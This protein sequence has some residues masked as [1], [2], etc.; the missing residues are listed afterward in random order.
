VWS[1]LLSEYLGTHPFVRGRKET[2]SV[3]GVQVTVCTW[4]VNPAAYRKVMQETRKK[5]GAKVDEA[6][7]GAKAATT[8]FNKAKRAKGADKGELDELRKAQTEAEA[9]FQEAQRAFAATKKA[10][11]TDDDVYASDPELLEKL[12]RGCH[13]VTF[14][15]EAGKILRVVWVRGLRKFTGL[16]STDEDEDEAQT[17]GKDEA[18]DPAAQGTDPAAPEDQ[19]QLP[20]GTTTL[21][22]MEKAN[23]ENCKFTLTL[24]DGTYYVLFGSKNT[25]RVLRLDASAKEVGAELGTDAAK[26]EYPWQ[27]VG[28]VSLRWLRQQ[29]PEML[30]KLEDVVLCGELMRPWAEH[31][32]RLTYGIEL[33]AVSEAGVASDLAT[34][35]SMFAELGID[36]KAGA[37]MRCVACTVHPAAD[38]AAVVD[39]VRGGANSEGAVIYA[40]GGQVE[41]QVASQV[42]G[43]SPVL[44]LFKV[45]AS[46][47]VVW[48]RVREIVKALLR[49]LLL[50]ARDPGA[51]GAKSTS[52]LVDQTKQRLRRGMSTLTHVPL[53][54]VKCGQWGDRACAFV[55][56]LVERFLRDGTVDDL[57]AAVRGKFATLV[58]EFETRE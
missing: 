4:K 22:V 44:G 37:E 38:L 29:T 34:T 57:A 40:V 56:Y 13:R 39:K 25:C 3:R 17:R 7:A 5:L 48:R 1:D 35:R 51:H 10:S 54:A 21:Y 8:A 27:N 49:S 30:K 16:L 23:G 24:V 11:I 18:T 50:G 15:D 12:P 52:E 43:G 33:Y 41:G 31:L 42:T 58:Y 32:V 9:R 19:A 45:K 47:Y 20:D 14:T 2:F 28:D 55:D 53:C 6:R 46:E 36:A 26:C